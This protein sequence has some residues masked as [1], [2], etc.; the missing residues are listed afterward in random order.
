MNSKKMHFD[1]IIVGGG[2]SGLACAKKAAQAGFSVALFERKVILGPKVCAGGI[3][4]NGLKK[5]YPKFKA[6]RNNNKQFLKT[7]LQNCIIQAE[8]PIVSTVD[9]IKLGSYMATEAINAGAKIFTSRHVK[10]ISGGQIEVLDKINN[11]S[12]SYTFSYLVGADGSSSIVRRYLTIPNNNVGVGINYTI[13]N[14]VT[15]MEWH[16]KPSFFK[17]GYG[18]VFPHKNVVSVGA[19]CPRSM[20][21]GTELKKQCV[22]WAKDIGYDLMGLQCSAELINYDFKGLRF[23]QKRNIFLVGDA[24]GLASGLTGEGIYP[25][26]VSGEGVVDM[27]HADG[28]GSPDLETIIKNHK[29]HTRIVKTAGKFKLS[30]VVLS[31]LMALGYK[32]NLLK[33]DSAEMA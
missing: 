8:H 23:G 33:F 15:N 5:Y 11:I 28:D 18:W 27:I 20:M 19:Y 3:T 21:S 9:R 22:L 29:K 13:P 30:A 16:I 24:A 12:K 14:R 2:P 1:V 6:E 10:S 31:E 26:I 32:T 25:A 4:W 17:N 7:A